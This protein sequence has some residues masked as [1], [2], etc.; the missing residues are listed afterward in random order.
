MWTAPVRHR[1]SRRTDLD[2]IRGILS[3]SGL[4]APDSDRA[5]LRRFRRIVADLGSDLYVAVADEQVIGVVHITYSRQLGGPPHGCLALLAVRPDAR[6]HG[7]GT[8]LAALAAARARRRGCSVVYTS[9]IGPAPD[10]RG[11]LAA[12]GWRAAGEA[13]MLE[14]GNPAL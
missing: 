10:A 3:A 2:S 8:N 9:P 14:L 4:P 6:R 11:F 12:I 1:R 13:F 7:I 5:A